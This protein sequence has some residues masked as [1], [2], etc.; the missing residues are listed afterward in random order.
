MEKEQTLLSIDNIPHIKALVKAQVSDLLKGFTLPSGYPTA[1]EL[2][3]INGLFKEIKESDGCVV[4]FTKDGPVIVAN[5]DEVVHTEVAATGY[6]LA[7]EMLR[8]G[9]VPTDE[10]P[11]VL[12]EAFRLIGEERSAELMASTA[13]TLE[14]TPQLSPQEQLS[15]AKAEYDRRKAEREALMQEMQK[16][17][18][19]AVD[20]DTMVKE[21]SEQEI[22]EEEIP[23]IV[24]PSKPI[25]NGK[26]MQED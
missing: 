23:K 13:S 25:D 22:A 26:E 21:E 3:Y 24:K 12:E 18:E 16:R 8:S 2:K 20:A 5:K 17:L 1:E 15:Q 9:K 7:I 10:D 19:S 11:E 6:S 14:L 4:A